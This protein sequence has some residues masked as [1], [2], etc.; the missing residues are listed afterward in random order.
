MRH[1][2]A[3][4]AFDSMIAGGAGARWA[5][6]LPLLL[7]G[8]ACGSVAGAAY[9]LLIPL[10]QWLIPNPGSSPTGSLGLTA[11]GAAAFS[12]SFDLGDSTVLVPD[13]LFSSRIR[14][15]VRRGR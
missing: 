12:I 3:V 2:V 9:S 5:H 15:A 11:V 7:A 10:P 1:T 4:V 8:M 13:P 6:P 14:L